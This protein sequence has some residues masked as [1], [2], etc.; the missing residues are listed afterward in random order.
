MSLEVSMYLRSIGHVRKNAV[1]SLLYINHN[2]PSD[3]MA[4]KVVHRLPS[5]HVK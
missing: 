5:H 1:L 4:I 2:L 3:L